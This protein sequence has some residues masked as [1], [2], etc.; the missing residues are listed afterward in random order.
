MAYPVRDR[1]LYK[2]YPFW[3]R[4]EWHLARSKY[5]AF[6]IDTLIHAPRRWWHG[7]SLSPNALANFEARVFSQNG[8][9]GILAEI[10]RR[11][12]DGNRYAVE[13]GIGNGEECCTRNL[14]VNHGWKGLL[15]EGS[16]YYAE[17]A[18]RLFAKLPQVRVE[19]RFLDL[20]NIL[21]VL[22]EMGVPTEPDLLVVDVDSND[23][24]LW[25]CILSEY[26][27]RVV[28]IEYNGRFPPPAKWVMPYDT[29]YLWDGSAYFGASL[30]SL[31]QLG[32]HHGYTLVGCDS[33]GV[34]A[35][36]VRDEDVGKQFPYSSLGLGHFVVPRYG[37]GFG[38]SVRMRNQP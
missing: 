24:Y 25:E 18:Q 4:L 29:D 26:L 3:T 14:F 1:Q 15:L 31:M 20:D 9:D 6:A 5:L 23:Y 7:N 27:P 36:F 22:C 33:K 34:N 19:H 30:A 8:E 10:F 21:A 2:N 28:V 35:F 37:R 38:H 32:L 17:N 11:I 13:F 12:G 16:E